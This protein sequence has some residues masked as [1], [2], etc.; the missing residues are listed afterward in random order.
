VAFPPT[1]PAVPPGNAK[2][3]EISL[4]GGPSTVPLLSA[5]PYASILKSKEEAMT[6]RI[7]KRVIDCPDRRLRLR[8]KRLKADR[9]IHAN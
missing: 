4:P 9:S 6:V 2:A 5:L 7:Y 8:F 1:Y 3:P